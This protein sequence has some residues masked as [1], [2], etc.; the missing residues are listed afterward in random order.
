MTKSSQLNDSEAVCRLVIEALEDIKGIDIVTLDVRDQT[1]IADFMVVASGSTNRQVKSLVD[2]VVV[3]AKAKGINVLSVE[4]Q[5]T[6]EWVLV[7]LADVLVHVMLPR[8]RD[9]YDLE[10]LWS[11]SP[12]KGGEP[13]RAHPVDSRD[14]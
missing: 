12:G 5:D 4:G 11:M 3:K 1:D 2:S 8:V 6:G 7:D 14:V 13:S 9:F 10:R